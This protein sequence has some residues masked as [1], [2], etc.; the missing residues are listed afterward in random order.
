MLIDRKA[1]PAVLPAANIT[2]QPTKPKRP[3][4]AFERRGRRYTLAAKERHRVAIEG[5]CA[6]CSFPFFLYGAPKLL[7]LLELP[8]HC[9]AH[10]HLAHDQDPCASL[11]P[12]DQV[13]LAQMLEADDPRAGRPWKSKHHD[14]F[15]VRKKPG[16]VSEGDF[17]VVERHGYYVQQAYRARRF[18]DG[19]IVDMFKVIGACG[20]CGQLFRFTAGKSGLTRGNAPIRCPAHSHHTSPAKPVRWTESLLAE[21]KEFGR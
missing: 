1:E 2:P 15:S 6:A 17:R 21:A 16:T 10:R 13:L 3:G 4:D 7:T 20:T 18:R 5:V 8:R 11:S 9:P 14:I 19:A 12:E